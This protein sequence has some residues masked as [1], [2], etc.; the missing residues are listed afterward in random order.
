M[1]GKPVK[2][3]ARH[4]KR[5]VVR[6]VAISGTKLRWINGKKINTQLKARSSAKMNKTE[7]IQKLKL[8]YHTY[9][10]RAMTFVLSCFF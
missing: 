8:V 9:D 10:R 6:Q 7:L 2:T 1:K 5:E 4:V 3:R